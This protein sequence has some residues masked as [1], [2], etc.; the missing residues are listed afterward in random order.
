M[1]RTPTPTGTVGG[2]TGTPTSTLPPT[3]ASD[4]SG[5]AMSQGWRT[6]VL[7]LAALLG[8][9]L[10]LTPTRTRATRSIRRR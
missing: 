5:G 4:G 9:V 1:E 2:A 8:A 7:S 3:D 10:I 6:V